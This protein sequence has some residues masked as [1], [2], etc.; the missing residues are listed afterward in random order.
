MEKLSSNSLAS[1]FVNAYNMLDHSLRTQYNFKANISFSDLIRRTATLNQVIRLYEDELIDLARLRNAIIHSKSEQVIAEPHE[2][3]V[4]TMEKVAKIISTPPLV[5]DVIKKINVDTI[6]AGASM[7]DYIV[8]SAEVGHSSV[9]VYKRDM[10]VGVLQRH[11]VLEGLGH[12]MKSS[13]SLDDFLKSTTTEVFLRDFPNN[14]NHF[15]ITSSRVT[16]EEVL[17]L[18]TNRKLSAVIITSDGTSG[19]KL[20]GIVTNA[21]VLNLMHILEGY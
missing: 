21:D 7:R 14:K 11:T 19:G 13:R 12:V 18:F 15:T 10:L 5:V 4:E 3:V 6:E 20:T 1:R 16:I 8:M 9:P 17:E 2:D